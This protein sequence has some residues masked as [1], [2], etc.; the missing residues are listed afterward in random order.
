MRR[1]LGCGVRRDMGCQRSKHTLCPRKK[2]PRS[3]GRAPRALPIG[4]PPGS[5]LGRTSPDRRG[6]C[7]HRPKLAG[8]PSSTPRPGRSR[9]L[10]RGRGACASVPTG[11]R[12]VVA[13]ARWVGRLQKS[14][15]S[16]FP[17]SGCWRRE[18]STARRGSVRRR[19]VSSDGGGSHRSTRTGAGGPRAFGHVREGSPPRSQGRGP[20]RRKAPRVTMA[21]RP[22]QAR[23][24]VA[25]AKR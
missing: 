20:N 25:L 16:I 4:S 2:T 9:G 19:P 17:V 22:K 1:T 21:S 3:G 10:P 23:R 15:R 18:A 7:V 13:G 14:V 8:V 24:R 11:N 5:E 12:T 6:A